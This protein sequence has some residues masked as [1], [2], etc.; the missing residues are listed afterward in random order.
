[1]SDMMNL[2]PPRGSNKVKTNVFFLVLKRCVRKWIITPSIFEIE[3]WNYLHSIENQIVI[4]WV[5]KLC[6]LWLKKKASIARFFLQPENFSIFSSF[7][8]VKTATFSMFVM[9]NEN[10]HDEKH[11]LY[12]F[13]FD[14]KQ[15]MQWYGSQF[16][17]SR[18]QC[19]RCQYELEFGHFCQM[20]PAPMG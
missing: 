5:Q 18:A 7:F 14:R 13:W 16:F 6:A 1:M 10:F 8:S 9:K 12:S 15:W 20:L 11:I 2:T 19:M 17:R 4:K 3:T